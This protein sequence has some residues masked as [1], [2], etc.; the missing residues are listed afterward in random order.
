MT[1]PKSKGVSIGR[2]ILIF[3]ALAVPSVGERCS[4]AWAQASLQGSDNVSLNGDAPRE[5]RDVKVDQNLGGRI[6]LDLALLDSNGRQVE[7]GY[8]IDGNKPTIIT[9]NYSDCPMLC[10]VQLNQLAQSLAKL[11]LRIGEDFQILTVSVDPK[12]SSETAAKTKAKYVSLISKFQPLAEDGWAFCT[13]DQG[14]I[15]R[16]A[17]VLGFRYK[18]DEK[19]G[20][21]YHPAMLA[22]VSPEGVITRYSLDVGFEPK[23]MRKAL[24]EAGEGTVGTPVDQLV[25]WCFSYDPSTNS[26]VP[27]AWKIMRAGGAATVL[28]MLACLAPYWFGRKRTPK[29]RSSNEAESV[30]PE[31]FEAEQSESHPSTTPAQ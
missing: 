12:E 1:R 2:W 18:Y 27:Q 25:L 22:F 19:S 31:S 10:S 16:L 24:V 20:E 6:P 26:Y 28:L 5:V 15:T 4:C 21:Y 8:F 3:S 29:F 7:S 17:D 11:D 9:L 30:G 13:A 23:D 14:T